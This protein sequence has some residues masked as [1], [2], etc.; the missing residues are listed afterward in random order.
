VIRE[1]PMKAAAKLMANLMVA[2]KVSKASDSFILSALFKIKL[3]VWPK[4]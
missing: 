4:T 3:Q 2:D 1:T